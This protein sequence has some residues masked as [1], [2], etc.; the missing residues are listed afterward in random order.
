M[1]VART[2]RNEGQSHGSVRVAGW[3][4]SFCAAT[5]T[6][7]YLFLK[8]MRLD[9]NPYMPQRL[10]VLV[11]YGEGPHMSAFALLPLGLA[12]SWRGLRAGQ[13][14]VVANWLGFAL[15]DWWLA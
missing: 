15:L 1:C 14:L 8:E 10:N 4:A 9:T 2:H 3:L 7:T 13:T 5:L 11:R 12:L 6:P